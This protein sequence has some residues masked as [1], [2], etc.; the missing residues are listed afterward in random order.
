MIAQSQESSQSQT[1]YNESLASNCPGSLP[2][3]SDD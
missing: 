3:W 1:K 2:N